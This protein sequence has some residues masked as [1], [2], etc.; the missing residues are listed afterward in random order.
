MDTQYQDQIRAAQNKCDL[1]LACLHRVD[2]ALAGMLCFSALHY[3]ELLL[4]FSD[5]IFLSLAPLADAWP[6]STPVADEAVAAARLVRG[7]YVAPDAS[8]NVEDF[9]VALDARVPH[10]K[11]ALCTYKAG[12]Q[13]LNDKLFRSRSKPIAS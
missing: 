6:N 2:I 10:V 3:S 13:K 9:V 5:L 12:V 4:W 7:E 1:S 11:G 8:R